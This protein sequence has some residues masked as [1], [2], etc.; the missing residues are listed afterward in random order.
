V[1]FECPALVLNTATNKVEIDRRTCI[2]CG[3]CIEG[4]YK[5]VIVPLAEVPHGREFRPAEV[6]F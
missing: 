4:C 1:A 2:D 5:D 6:A 3:Q